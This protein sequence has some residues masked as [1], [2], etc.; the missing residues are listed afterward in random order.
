MAALANGCLA[1]GLDFE[2]YPCWT[3]ESLAP[4]LAAI[5]SE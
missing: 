1:H 3:A 2:P 4:M 5:R